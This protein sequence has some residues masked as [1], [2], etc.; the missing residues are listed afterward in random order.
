MGLLFYFVSE[1]LPVS[2][3]FIVVIFFN[4]KL[5]SGAMNGFI[6]FIQFIDTMLLDANGFILVHPVTNIVMS[7][8]QFIYR[9]FNLNFFTLDKLSFC[10]WKG[11]NTLDVLAFKYVTITYALLLVIVTVLLMRLCNITQ[12]KKSL[13]FKCLSSD[14]IKSTVVHGISTFL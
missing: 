13:S 6:F 5:T 2:V 7:I 1:I 9:M 11:A 12:L 8:Y 3:M 14:D 4:V 10:L